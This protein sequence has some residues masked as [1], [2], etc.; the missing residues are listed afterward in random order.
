MADLDLDLERGG[1]TAA[2]ERVRES[3]RVRVRGCGPGERVKVRG[4]GPGERGVREKGL[5]SDPGASDGVGGTIRVT[6]PWTNQ[7]PV[8][9]MTF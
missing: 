5:P 2:R 6:C 9:V 4:C 3:A 8:H 7:N 1:E